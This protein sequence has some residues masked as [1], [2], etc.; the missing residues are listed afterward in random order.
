M[1]KPL[2]L[3]VDVQVGFVNPATEHVLD[4]IVDLVRLADA[5]GVPVAFTRFLNFAG[6]GWVKWLHWSRFMASPEIDL[7]PRVLPLARN[8]FDKSAYG[9]FTPAF[10]EFVARHEI[11]RMFLCGVATDGCVLKSAVDAFE[12]DIEP[13]VI[14]DACASHA[15]SAVHQ[16]GLLLASRFLGKGQLITI[17]DLTSAG[18]GAPV[19]AARR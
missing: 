6:S 15:G 7:H 18:F 8:V 5:Q 16:A 12:R 2:L 13:F 10:V 19:L 4:P 11:D 1:S 3:V 9:A 17:D 14:V